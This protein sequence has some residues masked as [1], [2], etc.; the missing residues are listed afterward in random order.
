MADK[1]MFNAKLNAKGLEKSVTEDQARHMV[2]TQGQ[3][4][5]FIV[6][7]RHAV[8]TI[9]EDGT[10]AINLVADQV[11]YVPPAHEDRVRTFMRALY[12][13]RPEQ[14]GQEAFETPK[15]GEVDTA[16]AGAALDAVVERDE[17]GEPTGV[18]DGDTDDDGSNVVAGAFATGPYCPT[19]GCGQLEEHDGDHDEPDD[20]EPD[21]E[22]EE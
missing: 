4:S 9:A 2:S 13:A 15:A 22:P 12:L 16:T 19:P 17:K 18:W 10:Q 7:A 8:I 5:L 6:D 21:D 3:H 14:Y 20:D 11:E 1:R